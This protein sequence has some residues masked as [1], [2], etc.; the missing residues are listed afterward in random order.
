M[1]EG[2]NGPMRKS[3]TN[4]VWDGV[5]CIVCTPTPV[6]R[7]KNVSASCATC[8]VSDANLKVDRDY[9]PVP[10]RTSSIGI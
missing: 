3:R 7:L 1:S 6:P 4:T 5:D 2:S 9:I 8:Q 10:S